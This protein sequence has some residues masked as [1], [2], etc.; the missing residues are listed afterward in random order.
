MPLRLL[1]RSEERSLGVS[2]K[3]SR[4]VRP[5]FSNIAAAMRFG[6]SLCRNGR[7]GHGGVNEPS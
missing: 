3:I 2:S 6:V 5:A 4:A 1:Q 7:S